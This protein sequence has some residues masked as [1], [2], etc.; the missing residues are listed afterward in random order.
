ML[1]GL[2]HFSML[3]NRTF[4]EASGDITLKAID[5]FPHKHSLNSPDIPI[6]FYCEWERGDKKS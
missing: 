6:S 5:F 3:V 2:N 4:L 1:A